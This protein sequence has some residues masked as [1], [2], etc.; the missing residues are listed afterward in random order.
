M[1]RILVNLL[2]VA[3][4]LP[5][6]VRGEEP[7]EGKPSMNVQVAATITEALARGKTQPDEQ[8][9]E[10]YRAVAAEVLQKSP[11]NVLIADSLAAASTLEALE[12]GLRTASEVLAFRVRKEAELPRG[13]PAPTPVGEIQLKQY[14]AYRLARAESQNDSGFMRLFTHIKLNG[15]AMT[16]PVEMTYQTTT[17][18]APQQIDMAFLY[19]D[20]Q[21]GKPGSKFGGV[22]VQDVAAME[23]VTIGLKGDSE[24]TKLAE[25][26]QRLETWLKEH[27]PDYV[28]AGPLRLMG[29]NSPQIRPELRYYEVEL[30]VKKR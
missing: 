12:K 21:A 2:T 10:T 19:G 29:Y 8:R 23:T 20:P 9:L 25:I 6:N 4:A 30:P 22:T 18:P 17:Q 24:R 7:S 28:R 16:A 14:P 26:E 11:N 13:F 1:T 27:A 3:A 5:L 15:I